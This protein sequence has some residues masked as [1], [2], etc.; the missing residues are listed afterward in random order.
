LAE[1]HFQTLTDRF[2]KWPI[3]IAEMSRFRSA[4]EITLAAKGLADGQIDIVV[5]THKLLSE[6]VKFKDLGLLIIDEEHRFGVRHKEA[7]KAI[8][9]EVDVLTLTATPIPAHFGH[10]T[11]RFARPQRHRNGTTKTPCNQNF[12][13]HRRQ[14]RHP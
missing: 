14:W 12:C 4:K 8:R 3:K 5:G 9:A 2:S 7:M 11:R 10:G 1:Q 6:S 13:S